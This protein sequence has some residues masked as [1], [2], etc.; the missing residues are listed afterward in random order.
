MMK[1]ISKQIHTFASILA[2]LMAMIVIFYAGVR[3]IIPVQDIIYRETI[4]A[5]QPL[6]PRTMASSRYF[7]MVIPL[8]AGLVL[9]AGLWW[10]KSVITWVGWG[11]LA[12][13]SGLFMFG[14]GGMFLP[15]AGILLVLL[16]IMTFI[17][18]KMPAG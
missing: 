14:V 12:V 15:A 10:R 13:F 5:S 4:N 16:L 1:G 6:D 9:L 8:I 7:T 18:K 17:E 3:L 2:I 11:V